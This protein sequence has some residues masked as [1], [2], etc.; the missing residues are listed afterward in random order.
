M[1]SEEPRALKGLLSRGK[2][3]LEGG[4]GV[5]SGGRLLLG[6]GV[7]S[8]P[9][10]EIIDGVFSLLTLVL[11]AESMLSVLTLLFSKDENQFRCLLVN[12]LMFGFCP[13]ENF[14]SVEFSVSP[15]SIN[16]WV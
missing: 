1:E 11:L 12:S 16:F 2:F 14:R 8:P 5:A 4:V 15:F 7:K 13:E 3:K 9:P 10:P 6:G